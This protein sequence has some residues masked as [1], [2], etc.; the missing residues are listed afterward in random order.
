VQSGLWFW[1]ANVIGAV[2]VLAALAAIAMPHLRRRMFSQDYL[3]GLLFQAFGL[4]ALWIGGALALG[5]AVRM[6]PG[7]VPRLLGFILVGLG[8]VISFQAAMAESVGPE[9]GKWR[10]FLL[11][12]AAVLAFAIVFNLAGLIPA[13]IATILVATLGGDDIKWGQ[14]AISLTFLILLCVGVFKYAL[15]LPMP[16]FELKV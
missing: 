16:L 1:G 12:P 14:T 3:A 10:P 8:A 15:N 11:V 4:L 13:I 9:R 7:Y 5:T 2:S 6:G